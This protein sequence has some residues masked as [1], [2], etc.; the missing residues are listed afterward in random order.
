MAKRIRVMM[1][2]TGLSDE[3]CRKHLKNGTVPKQALIAEAW[4]SALRSGAA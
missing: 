1:L 4:Q 2:A 3:C